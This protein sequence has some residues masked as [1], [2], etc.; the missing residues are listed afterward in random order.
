MLEGIPVAIDNLNACI[1]FYTEVLGLE[2]LVRPKALDKRGPGAWLG[3]E[4]IQFNS[5]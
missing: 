2:L 3:D 4:M 1:K 5:T